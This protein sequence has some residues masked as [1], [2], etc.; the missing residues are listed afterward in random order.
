MKSE[1]P[2]DARRKQESLKG[3]L[4]NPEPMETAKSFPADLEVISKPGSDFPAPLCADPRLR[5][6][7]DPGSRRDC[8]RALTVR[9]KRKSQQPGPSY[10]SLKESPVSEATLPPPCHKPLLL[11]M[12]S[13]DERHPD[14]SFS[15]CGSSPSSSLRFGDSDSLSSDEEGG[16]MSVQQQQLRA[17]GS[18][19]IGSPGSETGMS[20]VRPLLTRSSASRSHKWARLD[21]ENG[22][23]KRPCLSSQ[24]PL[25]RKRFVKNGTGG[26][27]QRT[28][29]QKERIL[30]QRKKREVIARKKYALL[31]STS[32]SSEE[33]T[34]ESSSPSS[35]EA[36]D[37][38]Y[39][40]VSS[41]SS[42][43]STAAVP[44]GKSL[45]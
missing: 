3:P 42:Q 37:E 41:S 2:S 43:A 21:P 12:R 14:S 29:K 19:S 31:H 44:S 34:S 22:H 17:P 36:E 28:P 18:V 1:I 33:L 24:K 35:T 10:C 25:H 9:K 40:D 8:E 5:P 7:R 27:A 11:G 39:V 4:A 38:L 15:D 16:P 20:D 45:L 26:G 23:V 13:E 30:L 32:S 6:S